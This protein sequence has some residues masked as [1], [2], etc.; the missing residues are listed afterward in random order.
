MTN[1]KLPRCSRRKAIRA[2]VVLVVHDRALPGSEVKRA[3]RSDAAQVEGRA[4]V[5]ISHWNLF[6]S[7][8]IIASVTGGADMPLIGPIP[9]GRTFFCPH[10]GA[11]YSVTYSQFSKSDSNIA[12]CVV[13]LQ[14]MDKWDS[15]KAPIYKLTHR[16]ED[17]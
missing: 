12:K 8:R 3:M 7:G 10:C 16:P 4:G 6:P 11:M 9:E 5:S 1:P 17:P 15:T 2:R 13:C 14:I